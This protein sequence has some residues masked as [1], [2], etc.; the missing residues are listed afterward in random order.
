MEDLEQRMRD[1]AQQVH[2]ENSA[3]D[4][5]AVSQTPFHTHNGLDSPRIPFIG[6]SDVPTSYW[7]N[8]TKNS[9]GKSLI[10]NPSAKGIEFSGGSQVLTTT[11]GFLTLPYCA[12]TPT[13][14]PSAGIGAMILDI[15]A[16][17]LWIWTGAA[18][19]YS[20]LT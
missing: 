11:D 7:L 3:I 2:D 12:G 13:G 6:L 5:F 8:T 16:K 4:Q 17:K 19:Q 20:Q 18:W 10:V 14:I 1:I 9:A 15:T